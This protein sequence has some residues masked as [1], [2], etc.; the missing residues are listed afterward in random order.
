MPHGGMTMSEEDTM[1]LQDDEARRKFLKVAGK[2]AVTA[3]ATALL[4]SVDARTAAAQVASPNT[5]TM[6]PITAIPPG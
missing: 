1:D 6:P 2:I 3:P 4:L 5:T